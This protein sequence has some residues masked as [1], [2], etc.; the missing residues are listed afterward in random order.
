M[1]RVELN[2]SKEMKQR[3]NL[4]I[5][6]LSVALLIFLSKQYLANKQQLEERRLEQHPVVEQF[7]SPEISER[8]MRRQQV[9]QALATSLNTPW[10][11]M[12]DAIE[13]V[14]LQHPEVYLKTILP[15]ANKGEI[16]ITGQVGQL[17][18]LLGFIDSLNKH[19]LFNDV[20]PLSQRQSVNN[21]KGI[22]F[23]LKLGWQS[24]E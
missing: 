3:R 1:K 18:R 10:Y 24:H 16:L 20:L 4:L 6:V 7:V 5:I 22:E 21:I 9:A 17:D 19:T 15:D 2:F 12:L 11:Q 8:D 23:S 14:K 13:Q